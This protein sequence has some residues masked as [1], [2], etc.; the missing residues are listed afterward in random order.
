MEVYI[1][2]QLSILLAIMQC[3]LPES[4]ICNQS[5][6]ILISYAHNQSPMIYSVIHM[7]K[8]LQNQNI[9]QV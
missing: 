5:S 8:Q 6:L 2:H 9:F 7:N 1:V 4:M 3:F